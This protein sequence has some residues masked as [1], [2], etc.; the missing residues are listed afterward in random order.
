MAAVRPT[1]DS[2]IFASLR[3]PFPPGRSRFGVV[4]GTLRSP[5]SADVEV[6]ERDGELLVVK[7]I[8][9]SQRDL[10]A[11]DR[12]RPIIRALV[13]QW[14]QLHHPGIAAILEIVHDPRIPPVL[15]I[16]MPYFSNG[17]AID[18]LQRVVR[19]RFTVTL[20]L[21]R[22]VAQALQYLHSAGIVHKDLRGSNILVS[23]Q[24]DAILTDIGLAP[25]LGTVGLFS[26][27]KI[28]SCARWAPP[29]LIFY[30]GHVN[31]APFTA[32]SD[33]YSF[34][35]TVYE[36]LTLKKPFHNI[37]QETQ[38]CLAIATG[39]RP[40]ESDDCDPNLNVLRPIIQNC[41]KFDPL[42]RPSVAEVIEALQVYT[43]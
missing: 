21:A 10:Q 15:S 41:W 30:E 32:A 7:C 43:L 39:G 8:R 1:Y 38:V 35:M 36:M 31:G 26:Y 40:A 27:M 33:V 37:P 25:V 22:Q 16:V 17:N 23:E 34:G 5:P 14:A 13:E 24:G 28:F 2:S 6:V 19:N 42:A 18:Y 11:I 12:A 20:G 9:A 29:E 3:A 4:L